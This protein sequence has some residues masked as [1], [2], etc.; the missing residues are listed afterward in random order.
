[1]A[2]KGQRHGSAKKIVIVAKTLLLLGDEGLH[3]AFA[4]V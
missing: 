4:A 1:L 2:T 3:Q